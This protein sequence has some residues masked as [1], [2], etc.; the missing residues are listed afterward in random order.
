MDCTDAV[1]KRR[2]A[3]GGFYYRQLVSHD[4]EGRTGTIPT[5]GLDF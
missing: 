5:E 1:S 4:L 2:Q 3:S